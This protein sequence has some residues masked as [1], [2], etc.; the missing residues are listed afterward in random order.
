MADQHKRCCKC[1]TEKTTRRFYTG[2]SVFGLFMALWASPI[3]WLFLNFLFPM[4]AVR[5]YS[6]IQGGILQ[7][8]HSRSPENQA[9]HRRLIDQLNSRAFTVGMYCA[10]HAVVLTLSAKYVGLALITCFI[11]LIYSKLYSLD[12]FMKQH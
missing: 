12:R 3:G 2:I 8:V 10:Y 7:Y 6:A 11:V 4:L 5:E 9:L 1:W